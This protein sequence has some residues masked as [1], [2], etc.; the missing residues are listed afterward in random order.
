MYERLSIYVFAVI[1]G[2]V[3][4]QQISTPG[5]LAINGKW[6]DLI[7]VNGKPVTNR[8][9]DASGTQFFSEV[10][11]Y[12]N[13]TLVKGRVF[14]SVKAKID[15][16]S[17]EVYFISNGMEAF[18][19]KGMV[20]E[21][22]Y[23]DTTEAGIILYK[24]KTGFPAIDRQTPDNFYLV[25]AEGHCSFLKLIIKKVTEKKNDMTNETIKEFETFEDYYFFVNGEI[26]RWKK[27]KDFLLAEMADKKTQIEQF[28]T[29]NKTNFRNVE[30]V[31]KLVNYY[32]SL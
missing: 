28:I 27:D 7:I 8:H 23:T 1:C 16:V 9:D 13:I 19:N 20:R 21:V 22:T 31:T 15:L 26:K 3:Q 18:M 6:G 30:G 4:A 10:Y 29:T 11:K 32:N 12:S 5:T 14:I 17:Q 2:G 24:F 25:L